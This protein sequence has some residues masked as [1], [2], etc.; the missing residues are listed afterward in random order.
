[1]STAL[2]K[3]A[4]PEEMAQ[5]LQNEIDSILSKSTERE[6]YAE[7]REQD[8]V[9]IEDGIEHYVTETALDER[10]NYKLQNHKGITEEVR[11]IERADKTIGK[12]TRFVQLLFKPFEW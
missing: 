6:I 5:S 11:I 12:V 3:F 8:I 7:F 2:K 1:M 4:S 10:I 9:E